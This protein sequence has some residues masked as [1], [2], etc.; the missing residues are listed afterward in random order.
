MRSLT[1][2]VGPM[3]ANKSTY[4]CVLAARHKRLGHKVVLL[5]PAVSARGH[6]RPG[7][8]VT[9]NGLQFPAVDIDHSSHLEEAAKG[10]DLVWI[11]EPQL[12]PGEDLV[13]PSVQT[14]RHVS[15]V[16]VSGLSATSELEPF[17]TSMPRLLAVADEIVALKADCSTCGSFNLATRSV[18]LRG[19]KD[20]VLVGGDDVYDSACPT[21]W[22]QAQ[23]RGSQES[24]REAMTG[25]G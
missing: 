19:K 3:A 25:V 23:L 22:T 4:A 5:R 24:G 2:V 6:E 12:F 1:V 18:C 20:Q 10:F 21:C 13:F 9:R 7:L 11:D 8:L 17:G 16:V 15:D 14:I